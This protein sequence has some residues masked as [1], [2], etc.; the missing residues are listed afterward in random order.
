[1]NT[2]DRNFDLGEVSAGCILV[3]STLLEGGRRGSVHGIDLCTEGRVGWVAYKI[4]VG[5]PHTASEPC[6]VGGP[7]CAL[8]VGV[9]GSERRACCL[10]NITVGDCVGDCSRRRVDVGIWVHVLEECEL[11]VHV[12]VVEEEDG[13][14]PGDG[15]WTHPYLYQGGAQKLGLKFHLPTVS[16]NHDMH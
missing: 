4:C 11:T 14:E 6:G 12:A 15:N 2:S 7:E 9:K 13:V 3:F 8:G 1:M 10:V 5:I 16:T